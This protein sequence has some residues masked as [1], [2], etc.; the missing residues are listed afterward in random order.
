MRLST[1]LGAPQQLLFNYKT[2][3][4]EICFEARYSVSDV[5]AALGFTILVSTSSFKPLLD[6]SATNGSKLSLHPGT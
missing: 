6:S 1:Y 2:G 4:F 5:V 3:E